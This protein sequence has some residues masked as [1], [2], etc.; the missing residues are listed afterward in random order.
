MNTRKLTSRKI[1]AAI[2]AIVIALQ[3]L[4]VFHVQKT[5]VNNNDGIF[6][7]TLSNTPYSYNYIDHMYKRFPLGENGWLSGEFLRS[8]YMV[9]T[10]DRFDYSAV[11]FHQRLDNHPLL[12]YSLVHTICSFFPETYSVQYALVI[13]LFGML[14]IDA[15]L[16]LLSRKLYHAGAFALIPIAGMSLISAFLDLYTLPRMYTLLA[17]MTLWYQYLQ[18]S[19]QTKDVLRKS[20]YILMTVCVFLGTQTHYYFYVYAFFASL[21]TAVILIRK[22]RLLR[23][24]N[25]I[26]AGISG[27]CMSVILFPWVVWH[28]LYNQMDKHT[29]VHGWSLQGMKEYI[30]FVNKTAFNGHFV[31]MLIV[32]GVIAAAVKVIDVAKQ[33]SGSQSISEAGS[34]LC[35]DYQKYL[36]GIFLTGVLYSVVIFTLDGGNWYYE[37]GMYLPFLICLSAVAAF[38]GQSVSDRLFLMNNVEDKK[39]K[40][41]PGASTFNGVLVS[42]FIIVVIL[43]TSSVR[44][45]ICSRSAAFRQSEVFH[46][47]PDRY[48]ASACIYIEEKQDN[49]LS[50]LLLDVSRYAEFKKITADDYRSH[51]LTKADIAGKT[52]AGPVILYIP[53]ELSVKEIK[54]KTELLAA[55]GAFNIIR[56]DEE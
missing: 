1:S 52:A 17:F 22:H 45:N 56:W 40:A 20:D 13:N 48:A 11:Y 15:V 41:S 30:S 2:L 12:Y 46:M 51:G 5:V 10:A 39:S 34:R 29:N 28:I 16:I 7:F 44:D 6:T 49:L 32:F 24:I 33:K 42:L 37:T 18:L 14:G 50:N 19:F 8:N 38:L 4:L 21:I 3:I 27:I 53:S 47:I 31:R 23:L 9:E 43:G 55:D 54:G 35:A 25:Y 36:A 26:C